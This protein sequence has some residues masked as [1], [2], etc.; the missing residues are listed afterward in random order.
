MVAIYLAFVGVCQL[1]LACSLLQQY[2]RS[3]LP[4]WLK[5]CTM[6]LQVGKDEVEY[7]EHV[8]D[9]LKRLHAEKAGVGVQT[10][11]THSVMDDKQR[12]Q[13]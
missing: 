10:E 5:I 2:S 3:I 13:Q 4:T 6:L 1:L 8:Q 12:K 7:A 9:H 11:H